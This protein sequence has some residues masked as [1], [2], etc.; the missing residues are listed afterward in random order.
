MNDYKIGRVV[1]VSGER[2]F[3]S[4]LDHS[5][6][7]DTEEGVPPTM[8]VNLPSDTGPTPLLIGQPGTF[9]SVGLPSGRL[10]GMITKIDMKES[11]P[12]Q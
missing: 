4:L 5:D 8:I 2:I 9:V 7:G 1:G 3:I 10:L 12:L 6:G 11:A